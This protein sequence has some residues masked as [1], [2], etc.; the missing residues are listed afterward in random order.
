MSN[1][2]DSDFT[3]MDSGTRMISVVDFRRFEKKMD[4]MAEAI[5]KLVIVEERQSNQKVEIA[6]LHKDVEA[7]R[8]SIERTDRLLQQW[9]QRGIGAWVVVTLVATVVGFALSRGH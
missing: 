4:L 1:P 3:P 5:G 8:V 2:D 6:E 7:N 9:I